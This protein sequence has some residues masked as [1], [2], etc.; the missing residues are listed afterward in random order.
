MEPGGEEEEEEE[1]GRGRLDVQVQ[2]N[3][4][5]AVLRVLG[6]VVERAAHVALPYAQHAAP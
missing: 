4:V 3:V 6:R 1:G 2:R 5:V